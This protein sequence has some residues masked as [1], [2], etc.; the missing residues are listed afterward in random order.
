MSARFLY[1]EPQ[2]WGCSPHRCGR[3]LCYN[4][5]THN[6]KD[7]KTDTSMVLCKNCFD[8]TR[9]AFFDETFVNVSPSKQN[10]DFCKTGD[11]WC[12]SSSKKTFEYNH[13]PRIALLR[14]HL[15]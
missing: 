9:S 13:Y 12:L 8:S 10:C 4:F 6:V 15:K 14:A 11:Q 3:K 7:T 1:R 5:A 2:F